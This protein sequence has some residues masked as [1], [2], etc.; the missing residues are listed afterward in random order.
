MCNHAWNKS[1]ALE[2]FILRKDDG[3]LIKAKFGIFLD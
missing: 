3:A 1:E 2:I